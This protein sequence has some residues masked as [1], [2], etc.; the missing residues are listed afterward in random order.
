[1]NSPLQLEHY[2]FER[3]QCVANP[4]ITAEEVSAWHQADESR[5]SLRVEL[6]I[7][8]ESDREWQVVVEVCTDPDYQ[9]NS[10]YELSFSAVGMFLVDERF[11]HNDLE[12][13][14]RVNGASVL[15]SAMREFVALFTSRG[16]WGAVKLPT[17]NFRLL[18]PQ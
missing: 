11:E 7:N 18:A 6:G 13:L 3:M 9:P 14:I 15:Y 2:F 8:P 10:P 17:V 4:N 5:F 16:P 1:M 12:R